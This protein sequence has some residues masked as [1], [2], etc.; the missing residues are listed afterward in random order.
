MKEIKKA[1]LKSK[2]DIKSLALF[3]FLG[4][5]FSLTVSGSAH[6]AVTALT[7]QGG[8]GSSGNLNSVWTYVTGLIYGVP[9]KLI[10]V[11]MLIWGVLSIATR[12]FLMGLLVIVVVAL[13]F[14]IPYI[15]TGIETATL[16][17][18]SVGA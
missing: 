15:V 11:G 4:L 14:L 7:G 16:V 18:H 10:G 12:H 5:I 17:L 13:F 8:G 6:A 1:V 2:P 9:G 3:V